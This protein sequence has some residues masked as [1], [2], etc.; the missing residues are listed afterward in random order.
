VV[1]FIEEMRA[2]FT[3]GETD[4][5]ERMSRAELARA[6]DSGDPEGEINALYGLAAVAMRAHDF[7][8][9]RQLG[10]EALAVALRSGDRRLEEAPRHMLAG[11][12]RMAGDFPAAR[13]LYEESIA[14]NDYLGNER[15]VVREQHNLGWMEMQTNNIGR[16]R[17]LFTA[18]RVYVSQNHY[19]EFIPYAALDAAAIAA[20][21]G[22]YQQATKLLAVIATALSEDG[23]ILDPDDAI[24]QASLRDRLV[25]KLGCDTFDTEYGNGC[26]LRPLEALSALKR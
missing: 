13:V 20:A 25:T 18:V 14:L 12:A 3:R 26:G 1:S 15:R 2:A 17:E 21:D 5:V 19:R 6:R 10:E 9:T 16:A 24:E 22:A 8:R 11:A 7:S 4:T 23:Q